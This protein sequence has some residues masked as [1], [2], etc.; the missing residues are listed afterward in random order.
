[1]P[2]F[3]FN[4]KAEKIKV[5]A[6]FQLFSKEAGGGEKV[7]LFNLELI[8]HFGKMIPEADNRPLYEFVESSGEQFSLSVGAAYFGP[9][10]WEKG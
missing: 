4:C 2:K 9:F 1:M 8:K 10:K 5:K 3:S 7:N 6:L